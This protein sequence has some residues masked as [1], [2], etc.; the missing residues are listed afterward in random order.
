MAGRIDAPY[1]EALARYNMVLLLLAQGD[2]A[3]MRSQASALFT[4]AERLRDRFW[5]TMA[6]RSNED[7]AQLTGDWETARSLSNYLK[8]LN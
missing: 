8:T 3:G 7:V 1:A 4:I 2:L 6:L 5:L